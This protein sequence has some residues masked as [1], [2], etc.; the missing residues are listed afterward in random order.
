MMGPRLGIRVNKEVS[1]A[2]VRASGTPRI[3]SPMYAQTPRN[4]IDTDC[5]SSQPPGAQPLWPPEPPSPGCVSTKQ[6]L[7]SCDRF[8]EFRLRIAKSK[9]ERPNSPELTAPPTK[10]AAANPNSGLDNRAVEKPVLKRDRTQSKPQGRKPTADKVEQSNVEES[11]VPAVP[12]DA[13]VKT[14]RP[15]TA[16]PVSKTEK[17]QKPK[18]V[19]PGGSPSDVGRPGSKHVKIHQRLRAYQHHLDRLPDRRNRQL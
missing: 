5:P 17:P 11:N 7:S 19:L 6:W 10:S 13:P 3:E 1:N 14:A 15:T 9:P 2:S 12:A 4:V 8:K 18:K 16:A